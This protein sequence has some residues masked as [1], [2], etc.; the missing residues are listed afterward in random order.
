MYNDTDINLYG[1]RKFITDLSMASASMLVTSLMLGGCESVFDAIG[2][3]PVRR[4][5]RNTTEG[6]QARDIYRQAVQQMKGLLPADR[7]NW[8]NQ[9]NIHR[10][11]CPHQNW[12]FFPW[13]RVYLYEFEKICQKLTGESHF[14]LPYWNWCADGH[15]PD[16]YLDNTGSN[17]LYDPTRTVSTSSIA[18]ANSV[19]LAVVDPFCSEPD[20]ELFAGGATNSLRQRVSFGNIE[21]TPH[22][23]IHG[24]FIRGNMAD[25]GKAARDPIFYN[26]HCMVDLCWYERN[27]TR[28]L[29]NT[30]DTNWMNF[31]FANNFCDADGNLIPD[32]SPLAA[33]LMPI[34][35]YRYETGIDATGP[36]PHMTFK[37]EAEL[38]KAEEIIKKGAETKMQV[39][40]RFALKKSV[41]LSTERTASE[42]IGVN[43]E[44]F[45]R[46]LTTDV[47]ERV[48][49]A[50][51]RLSDPP[52]NSIFLR[53]FINKEDAGKDTPTNDP[54]YAGSFYFFTHGGGENM[55]MMAEGKP[56]LFVDITGTLRRIRTELKD[57]Q[58]V[59]VNLV[60]IPFNKEQAQNVT[61]F[62]EDIEILISPIT[63]K[64]M[65]LQ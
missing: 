46:I 31:N 32:I 65:R 47:K 63:V 23:Y 57:L 55:Q 5:L 28:N 54:H 40:E 15:V 50:I 56:D 24:G 17:A 26:H 35:S 1:R 60:A 2:N 58:N 16:G 59:K 12:F 25:I 6:N 38:K 29:P 3:R 61:I 14:G 19:G 52:G 11:F 37:N 18:D 62:A 9:A 34:L 30:N 41:P 53:V 64:L 4:M 36:A 48:I 20:F 13:H 21:A 27:I 8:L 39:K 44:N 7:R 33:L 45:S 43:T 42:T 51:K 10:D 22:N 49:L